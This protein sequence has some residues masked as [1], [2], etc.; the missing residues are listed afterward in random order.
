MD[1]KLKETDLGYTLSHTVCGEFYDNI[2]FEHTQYIVPSSMPILSNKFF[3][4]IRVH[5]YSVHSSASLNLLLESRVCWSLELDSR[6]ELDRRHST[7]RKYVE[8]A[9]LECEIF[10]MGAPTAVVRS[11]SSKWVKSYF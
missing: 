1:R 6:L 5:V 4:H 11:F 10:L 9:V 3:I 8:I 2:L 7:Q